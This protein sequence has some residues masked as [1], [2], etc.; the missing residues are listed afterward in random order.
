MVS[1][2]HVFQGV[3]SRQALVDYRVTIRLKYDMKRWGER[4][5]YCIESMIVV[6]IGSSSAFR[7]YI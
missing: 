6:S 4:F 3:F 7:I 5:V 1:A 2:K